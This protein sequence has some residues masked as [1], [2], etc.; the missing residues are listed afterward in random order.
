MATNKIATL[1]ANLQASH[2]WMVSGT[3]LCS[4][5]EDLHGELNFLKVWPFCLQK[6]GF[7]ES[8]IGTPFRQKSKEA[9]RLL[10][11]LLDVVMMRHSKNQRYLDGRP[12]VKMPARVIEWRPFEVIDNAE[13]FLLKWFEVFCADAFQ[14]FID[15]VALSDRD[16]A[17]APQYAHIRGLVAITS[18]LLTHPSSL[19]LSSL[20]HIRRLLGAAVFHFQGHNTA[21]HNIAPGAGGQSAMTATA[22]ASGASGGRSAASGPK[23]PLME[24]MEILQIVQGAG[25]GFA[26]GM[27]RDTNRQLTN[28]AAVQ[29]ETKLRES[30]ETYSVNQLR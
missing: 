22:G 21:N 10:Y 6:D 11:D 19:T 12:L 7:W 3:P 9:I 14:S 4:K 2:R 20:D 23:I 5:V 28:V 29:E 18:R 1:C 24:P 15:G 27:N 16:A 17:V 13:L 30:F 8:K 25:L 26:G